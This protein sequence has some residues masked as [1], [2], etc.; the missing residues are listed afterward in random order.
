M[1]RVIS[2]F[3]FLILEITVFGQFEKA[4]PIIK[5]INDKV[6]N[7]NP[8]VV[9]FESTNSE[10]SP[11]QAIDR[12][13]KHLNRLDS[14]NTSRSI[15]TLYIGLNPGDSLY[16][17]GDYTYNGTI[18]VFGD[19]KLVF[20]NCEALINGDLVVFGNDAK[21]WI[22]NSTMHFPQSFIYQRALIAAGNAEV[23]ITNSTLDYYGLSHDLV[24]TGDAVINW[25]EVTNIGFTTCGLSANATVN[26]NGTN[27]AGE[28]VMTN[29]AILNFNNANTILLWHHVPDTA[30]LSYTFADGAII[31]SANFNSST[32]GISGIYYSYNLE[33]CTDVMWGLMPEAESEVTINDSKIRTVGVWFKDLPEY[34]VSGLVNNSHYNDFT[35]PLN[36]HNLRFIN[37]D[38][39]T[40]S[41]YMF[42][43][44]EGN[45][46]NCILG[47]IG[48]MANG[49]CTAENCLI[50]GSG[51]YLFATDN[52]MLTSG[53]SYLN[54]NFQSSGEAFGIMAYGGQN[55]GRCIAFEKSIMII[56][57]ANLIEEPEFQNDA[58]LWYLKL[59]TASQGFSNSILPII[60]SARINKAS[61]YYPNEIGW[62]LVSYATAESEDWIAICDT[63]YGLNV[64]S[65]VLCNW[66]TEEINPG[67]YN[68]KLTMS[69]NSEPGNIIEAIKSISILPLSTDINTTNKN[70]IKI[71]PNPVSTNDYV[72]IDFEKAFT[73]LISIYDLSGR[74]LI[75]E[76]VNHENSIKIDCI[77]LSSGKYFV[78]VLNYDGNEILSGKICVTE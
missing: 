62:Y 41:L 48:T 38:V 66:N 51:G 46:A 29:S 11:I 43:N 18:A 73:G 34:E 26:I 36:S 5:S 6:F 23:N 13:K 58:M 4:I 27:Q 7:Q 19:G 53:F 50:D 67:N 39:Q 54:C 59:E 69:D 25:T 49:I 12:Q 15:D 44:T 45:V 30:S 17:T 47:E 33:N 64:S 37:T 28:Y 9:N 72:K 40:W 57:Q 75:E 68:L 21:V 14:F 56:V 31:S 8:S 76:S 24:V 71:Y 3:L 1:K 20:E 74:L 35:A 2:I 52:S 22:I 42:D 78:K 16:F 55:S 32:P 61:S 77:K 60:G 10:S 63:V 70:E 65:D